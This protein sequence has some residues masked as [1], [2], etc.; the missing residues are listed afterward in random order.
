[1]DE[2]SPAYYEYADYMFKLG[3]ANGVSVTE[4][5]PLGEITREQAAT[6]LMRTADVLGYDTSYNTSVESGVSS[7]ATEGVG[8]VT[9]NG[10]MNGTGNGFEP[11]GKYTK[12][13]AIATFV[14]MYDN[15]K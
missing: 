11:Q 6:M 15:L 9:E 3:I 1:M 5:N 12:E 10:I 2:W 4:F 7:W 14:R 13:Q 8:F